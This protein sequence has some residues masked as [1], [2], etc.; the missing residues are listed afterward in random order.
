MLVSLAGALTGVPI[1]SA[2]AQPAATAELGQTATLI[3]KGAAL[4][5]PVVSSGT[6]L[7]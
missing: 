7:R 5:V 4:Q 2:V 1:A 3:A 6:S